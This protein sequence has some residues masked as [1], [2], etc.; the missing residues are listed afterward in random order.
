MI[1]DLL[2]FDDSCVVNRSLC[3]RRGAAFYSPDKSIVVTD[4]E[5]GWEQFFISL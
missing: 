3:W 2:F 4:F 1:G 5:L